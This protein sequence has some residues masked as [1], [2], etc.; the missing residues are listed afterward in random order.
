M[1]LKKDKN[2]EQ[3]GD[4]LANYKSLN[5]FIRLNTSL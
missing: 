2:R 3:K 1:E 5:E 4:F